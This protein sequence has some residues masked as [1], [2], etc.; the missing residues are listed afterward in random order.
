LADRGRRADAQGGEDTRYG[1]LSDPI[2]WSAEQGTV[3][4]AKVERWRGTNALLTLT[5]GSGPG[6]F[7]HFCEVG[8]EHGRAQVWAT[9]ASVTGG[10]VHAP[11]VLRMVAGPPRAD[12][13]RFVDFYVNGTL[14]QRIPAYADL[15]AGPLRAFIYGWGESETAWDWVRAYPAKAAALE[16]TARDADGVPVE[17]V[18][19]DALG[20]AGACTDGRGR[21]RLAGL[22]AGPARV[23]AGRAEWRLVER[24]TTLAAG[25][26]ATADFQVER[27][28][29][30]G[31][32]FDDF[33][34]LDEAR[35]IVRRIGT[36]RCDARIEDGALALRSE[37]GNP[38]ALW[39]APV[40]GSGDAEVAVE[41]RISQFVGEAVTLHVGSGRRRHG[42]VD[43]SLR[44]GS[45]QA[46]S[47]ARLWW[48]A[49][50]RISMPCDLRIVIS[51]PDGQGRRSVGL[52]YNGL[53]RH[54]FEGI[55]SLTP[56][57]DLAVGLGAG[58]CSAK[59][60]W[61]VVGVKR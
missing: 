48:P 30:Q 32:L 20:I 45:L 18:W 29:S 4:E 13:R 8:I 12:G 11:A 9:D 31:L 58:N 53:L 33:P 7:S 60:E 35:W 51:A 5:G 6:D 25:Q 10:E 47:D 21:Y 41:A 56:G 15:G 37:E 38:I 23:V 42:T 40:A 44:D 24:E 14:L 36:G 49:E 57:E 26:V 16:G 3:I 55:E 54:T 39:S 28:P 34:T 1:L 59:W 17:G 50:A 52:W 27:A 46:R 43:W 61:V 2:P 19:V 22:P